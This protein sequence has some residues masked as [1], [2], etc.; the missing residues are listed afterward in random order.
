MCIYLLKCTF[1][2]NIVT[3]IYFYC[4][5]IKFKYRMKHNFTH[6]NAVNKIRFVYIYSVPKIIKIWNTVSDVTQPNL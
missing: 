4:I 6:C 3:E 5:L 1:L 2:I